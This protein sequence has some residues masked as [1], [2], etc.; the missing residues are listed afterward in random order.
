MTS[1]AAML[2][3]R[4]PGC[5]KIQAVAIGAILCVAASAFNALIAHWIHGLFP[6]GAVTYVPRNGFSMGFV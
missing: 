4:H 6:A 5:G 3:A 1:G 2:H